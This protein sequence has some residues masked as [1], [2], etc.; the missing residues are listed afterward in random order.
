MKFVVLSALFI[1]AAAAMPYDV[2]EDEDG[3][4]YIAVP[5]NREKRYVEGLH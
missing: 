2:I 4:Q 5:I 3:K 1:A